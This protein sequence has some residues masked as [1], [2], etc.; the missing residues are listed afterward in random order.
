MSAGDGSQM[1][2]LRLRSL[3]R[4]FVFC[5]APLVVLTGVAQQVAGSGG[6][7]VVIAN[8]SIKSV[9]GPPIVIDKPTPTLSAV[10][11]NGHNW[12]LRAD[13]GRPVVLFFFC[14]CRECH[15]LSSSWA[16]L[17][18]A[19]VLKAAPFST[20]RAA[21]PVTVIVYSGDA[22]ELKAFAK[23][24]GLPDDVVLI[25][26]PS[27]KWTNAYG[28][29]PCPRVFV[30]DQKG[31]LRYTN[32]GAADAPQGG[33]EDVIVARALSA[34]RGCVTVACTSHGLAR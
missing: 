10:D 21:S 9:A 22:A 18:T 24:T 28:V 7:K 20:A 5:F 6:G 23:E 1:L 11:V 4:V 8:A 12:T 31:A 30:L 29:D 16:G 13:L 32:N 15:N 27:M 25:P 14:G 34:L 3:N 19:G 33:H 26:D 2:R 17:M